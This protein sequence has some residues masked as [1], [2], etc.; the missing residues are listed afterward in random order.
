MRI[1]VLGVGL[2][3]GS[4]ALA[5]RER[6]GAEVLGWDPDPKALT[7]ATGCGAI[8]RPMTSPRE[9]GDCE[10][11]LVAGP[12][13]TLA[14]G[15]QEALA[16]AG[17]GAVVTDVGSTKAALVEATTDP[18]FIGGHPVAGAETSGV[19][20]AR[21][22]LFA[23]ATW[24]L[25]PRPDTDGE[26]YERLHRF[27]AGLG[28]VPTAIEHHEHDRVL[29]AVSHLPHVLANVLVAQAHA[30]LGGEAMPATGGSFRDATRV[31]GANPGLW[32]QIY[33]ENAAALGTQLDQVIATLEDVRGRLGELEAWQGR[34]AQQ[35]RALLEAETQG[36]PLAEL[37]VFVPNR[38]GIVADLALALGRAGINIF[39]MSLAPTQDNRHGTVV[40]W[41]AAGEAARAGALVA[42]KGLSVT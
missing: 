11:L 25:T 1:A 34:A 16:V 2:I 30:A 18:R 40:L 36:G 42:E 35:R 27:V 24:Y 10:L 14:T 3:G 5:A 4:V 38:P 17:P 31:A 26:L 9:A 37:R 21:A 20:H 32:A 15:V 23:G 29:A 13:A 6:L 28:A 8:D 7:A 22:D 12:V 19:A 41:V 39:D 33:A